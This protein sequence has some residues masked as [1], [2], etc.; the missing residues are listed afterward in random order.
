M[1]ALM[2]FGCYLVVNN[3]LYFGDVWNILILAVNRLFSPEFDHFVNV[4][5]NNN[6]L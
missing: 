6:V 3:A 1:T 2:L 5:V 4:Y